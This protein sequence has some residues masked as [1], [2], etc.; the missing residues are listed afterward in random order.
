M[1]GKGPQTSKPTPLDV[2][3]LVLAAEGSWGRSYEQTAL[4]SLEASVL[5]QLLLPSVSLNGL[6]I[7]W[8]LL[9]KEGSQDIHLF[10]P[11]QRNPFP[12]G[13]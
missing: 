13:R 9:A 6:P 8:V 10:Q 2:C 11:A 5:S 12:M 3:L 4:G 1:S 7:Q